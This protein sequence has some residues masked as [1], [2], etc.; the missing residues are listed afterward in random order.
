MVKMKIL[1][2]DYPDIPNIEEPFVLCLGYFDGVHLGH[3][4]MIEKAVNEG[5]KVAVMTFDNSPAYVLGKIKQNHYLTSVSDKAEYLEELKVDYLL[6]MHFDKKTSEISKEEFVSGVLQKLAPK[7]IFCGEDYLFGASSKGNPLYLK[8]FFDVEI[9]PLLKQNDAKIASRDIVSLIE[10]G[11]MDKIPEI[12]GRYYRING[13][14]VEGKHNGKK[15]EFPTANLEMNYPY[16]FPKVGVYI[17]YAYTYGKKYKAII[18]VGTHPTVMQLSKPIVEVHL[19]DYQGNLYGKDLFVEFIK[20]IR[21]E[22]TFAS[23][24]ELKEQLKKDSLK[25]KRNLK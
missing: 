12:L 23:L 18:S 9:V 4:S 15:I 8:E 11:K 3:K 16:V 2:F 21:D 5:Y 7:K 20:Y 19:L 6:L 17:G 10:E 1:P 24:D 25:A 14:V 13:T 22:K